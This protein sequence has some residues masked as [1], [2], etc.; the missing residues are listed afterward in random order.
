MKASQVVD[1][2]GS[3]RSLHRSR[4]K[5][6]RWYRIILHGKPKLRVKADDADDLLYVAASRL[7][8]PAPLTEASFQEV[9]G[10]KILD[11]N[12]VQVFPPKTNGNLH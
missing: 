11:D 1:P 4:Q 5:E 8:V 9:Q 3:E 6:K 12:N 7:Q 2:K 10:K